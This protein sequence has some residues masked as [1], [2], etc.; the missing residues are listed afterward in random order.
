MEDELKCPACRHYLHE[1]VL[2]Q[3]SH[4]Y[5]RE[6]A[7]RSQQK[8][9]SPLSPPCS[10]SGASDTMSVCVS[11]ADQESDKL[12]VVSESD[13]GV[14]IFNGAS[15]SSGGSG[16]GPSACSSRGSR[17]SSFLGCVPPAHHQPPHTPRPSTILTPSTFGYTLCCES[18]HKTSFYAD[19][20]A[21]QRQP[22][23]LALERLVQRY[24]RRSKTP[25]GPSTSQLVQDCKFC[26][27][28][29]RPVTSYCDSCGFF[30]CDECKP[31]V[32]PNRGPLKE[33]TIIPATGVA[34]KKFGDLGPAE[35]PGEHQCA[36]HTDETLTMFCLVCNA[37]V[38]CQCIKTSRHTNHNVQSLSTTVKMHKGD[39]SKILHEL[40]NKAKRAHEGINQL[41]QLQEQINVNCEEFK[42]SVNV[43]VDALIQAIEDRRSRLLQFVDSERDAKRQT[44]RDQ[45]HRCNSHLGKTTGLI[46]FCIEILKETDPMGNGLHNRTTETDFLWNKNMNTRAEVDAEFVLNLDTKPLQF[47]VQSLEFVQLKAPPKPFF[48]ASECSAENNSVVLAWGIHSNG[49]A[50]DGYVLELDSGRDDGR[51][52]E[53]YRGP[54]TICTIDGLHFDSLYTARLKAFNAAGESPLSDPIC[55]QT[56]HVAWFQLCK[57]PSQSDIQLLNDCSTVAGSSLGYQVVLG[58]V[59][60]SRGTHYWEVSVDR[61]EMNTDVVLGVASPSVNRHLMLGKDIHGWS[62]YADFQRS[63]FLHGDTHHG[64][65]DGGISAGSVVGVCLDCDRG[66][67][68]FFINDRPLVV[69]GTEFAFRNMPRGLYYPAASVNKGAT[70]TIHTGLQPPASVLDAAA[71][72][73]AMCL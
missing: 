8:A 32:H 24:R 64:R 18:C 45:I 17:P 22:V 50:V 49:T 55:L 38:C 25:D 59:A 33:H 68:R 66:S 39:L 7:V 54:E 53:V 28:N 21:L 36:E 41:K 11:D 4:S 62:I 42:T 30:F 16:G 6:C 29:A 34:I 40:S 37:P 23:N 5:C 47:A 69:E 43:Q 60:F 9:P 48:V 46:Q 61:L 31:I 19:E 12:S 65:R 44:L 71:Q 1:P 57:S 58:T 13:S 10:S 67:L 2:L 26:E 27:E 56:A 70:I 73:D 3:C 72:L 15:G 63:W 51:F 14:Y 52:K 35:P 20:S